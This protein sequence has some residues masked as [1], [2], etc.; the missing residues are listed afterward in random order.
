MIIKLFYHIFFSINNPCKCKRKEEARP[1]VMVSCEIVLISA[2]CKGLKLSADFG[3]SCSDI[4]DQLI[5]LFTST[6]CAVSES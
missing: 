3:H 2:F 6:I 1:K 4:K 5:L